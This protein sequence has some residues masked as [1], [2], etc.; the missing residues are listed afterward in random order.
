MINNYVNRYIEAKLAAELAGEH[1]S[2]VYRK[3]DN[4]VYIAQKVE[5]EIGEAEKKIKILLSSL[6]VAAQV[7]YLQQNN[8]I[9][10]NNVFN[11][12]LDI[13]MAAYKEKFGD[14]GLKD[15]IAKYDLVQK[16]LMIES[17]RTKNKTELWIQLAEENGVSKRTLDRM[18]S[19][20][21]EFGTKSLMKKIE[22]SNKGKRTSVCLEA[23]RFL[24]ENYV[25]KIRRTKS[26]V[27]DMLKEYN[28]DYGKS[29]CESC[30]YRE[31]TLSRKALENEGYVDIPICDEAKEGLKITN[32][33]AT[34]TR[35][36]DEVPSEVYDYVTKG[37]KYWEAMYMQKATRDKPSL[38][39]ECWFGDH[40][41]LDVFI[42]DK[43][44]KIAKP[45][46]TSWYDAASGCMVGWC[47]NMNPNS[48]TIAEAFA[49]GVCVKKDF[50]FF[51]P[52]LI[53]Y[54]DNG[55]DYRSHA[56]EGGKIIERNFGKGMPF[57]IET[58]G[59]LKQLDIENCHAKPYHGWAKPI[60][61]FFGTFA[62]RYVR[63]LPGW[64]GR[65][66]EERP[67]GFEKDLKKLVEQDK[68][69]TLDELKDWF[70][71]VLNDYH[72]TEHSGY[73]N[74]KPIDIYMSGE[75]ARYD[76]PSWA[77]LSILKME[78]EIRTVTTQGITMDNKLYWHNEL[79]H[80]VKEKVKVRFNRENKDILIVIHNG[81]FICAAPIKANLKMVHED[82]EK[83]AGHISNQKIQERELKE[84]IA[85]L[86]G[87]P[88]PK[89]RKQSS[90]NMLT[91]EIIETDTNNVT[92]LEHE[93]A[94][95][96]YNDEIKKQNIKA[97]VE[98]GTVD[99]RYRKTG[100]QLLKKVSNK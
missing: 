14:A 63:E 20:F 49:Y 53:V 12:E 88:K 91:G 92:V 26:K 82:D 71:G 24:M 100:E 70:I 89:V 29:C 11:H 97:Q 48:Q 41:V 90:T 79:R 60:E 34:I 3:A 54:T 17:Q 23:K 72:N 39:N 19:G 15:L 77:I 50:I 46:L 95:K 62:D 37:K 5:S 10:T 22:R 67:E 28:R 52:P 9:T 38:I 33:I 83:I 57:N 94:M 44:G 42:K 32:S 47:L 81:K 45:W 69:L 68:L 51:G 66:P 25:T 13:D 87:K 76:K 75:K 6:P 65:H 4:N 1:I 30:I 85:E 8:I 73:G 56:F 96:A 80:L 86:M 78:H 40:H 74:R 55:K 2:T 16:A 35:I 58:D 84:R 61:R 99:R 36:L 59:I 21:K 31:G 93:K 7:K 18:V 64:C 27:F 98:E 43:D